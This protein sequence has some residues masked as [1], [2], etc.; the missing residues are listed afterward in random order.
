MLPLT[1]CETFAD[2]C[3]LLWAGHLR[4]CRNVPPQNRLHHQCRLGSESPGPHHLRELMHLCDMV[5]Y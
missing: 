2:S 3:R 1:T 4:H 5:I